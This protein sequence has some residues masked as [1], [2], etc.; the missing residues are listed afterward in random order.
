MKTELYTVEEFEKVYKELG[1]D[2]LDFNRCKDIRPGFRS[3]IREERDYIFTKISFIINPLD[4]ENLSNIFIGVKKDAVYF[5]AASDINNEIRDIYN[6][7]LARCSGEELNKE[8]LLAL[9]F[10]LCIFYDGELAEEAYNGI[11]DLEEQVIKEDVN[12]HFSED[13]HTIKT[14]LLGVKGYYD[15]MIDFLEAI[16]DNHY[17]IFEESKMSR[18]SKVRERIVGYK[19][20]I[21]AMIDLLSQLQG[22]YQSYLDS[23][24]NSTMKLLTIITTIF[25]PLTL[26]VGWYGMNFVAMP[27]L[28]WDYGYSYVIALSII[29][30]TAVIVIAKVKK[31]F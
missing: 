4:T 14:Y 5:I 17:D 23:K 29:L 8:G 28:T 18:I 22:S 26:I 12:D 20:E 31:W 27:E 2:E 3:V 24:M 25:M 30:S 21:T 9:F 7:S 1:F 19:E 16:E 6:E 15:Q 10:R 11:A 13:L